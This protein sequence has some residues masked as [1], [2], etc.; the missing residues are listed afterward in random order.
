[1]EALGSVGIICSDKTGTLTMNRMTVSHM[2]VGNKILEI[3]VADKSKTH[4]IFN[5]AYE[6]DFT[7]T[8]REPTQS[9]NIDTSVDFQRLFR[10]GLLC[11]K[12]E[13]KPDPEN[14]NL[15]IFKRACK[16]D[17]CKLIEFSLIAS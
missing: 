11:N 12:A 2:W 3:N 9:F 17:A 16:G 1:M 4:A 15:E 8:E 5:Q 10:C 7:I 6:N 14:M 13:F